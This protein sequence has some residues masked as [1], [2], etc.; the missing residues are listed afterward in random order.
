[1]RISDWSSD[2]CS[3]DLSFDLLVRTV[4]PDTSV[5]RLLD[6]QPEFKAPIWDYLAGLVDDERVA[7]GQ[8]MLQQHAAPLARVQAYYG[9][10]P[11]PVVAVWGV[12]SD[13]GRV[14]GRRPLLQ[15]LTTLSCMG[16]SQEDRKSTRLNSSH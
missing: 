11:A 15:S 4:T 16:R 5:L 6:A 8:V 9:V 12:E 1:M 10:D 14:S 13:F 7:D 3:S 2:V